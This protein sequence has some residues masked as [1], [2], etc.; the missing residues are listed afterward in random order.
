MPVLTDE[1]KAAFLE[2]YKSL[3]VEHGMIV[4]SCSC[5]DSPWLVELDL[6]RLEKYIEHLE[7]GD[8]GHR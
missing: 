8:S 1:A 6:E 5:C 7:K 3:C 4:D 2:A